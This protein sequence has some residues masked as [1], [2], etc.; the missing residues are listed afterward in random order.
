MNLFLA[1]GEQWSDTLL[2]LGVPNILFSYFYFR[3]KL[4]KDGAAGFLQ[5]KKL[6]AAKKL[7]YR[8]M[9]DSGAF[10]YQMKADQVGR[11]LP[12]PEGYHREYLDFLLDYGDIFD[13]ICELDIDGVVNDPK[14]G[15]PITVQQVDE[16]TNDL[17]EH[18]SLRKKIMPVYHE[19]RGLAWFDDW[20]ADVQSPLMGISSEFG[21]NVGS[22]QA[23]I[24][25]A[26]R[27]GKYVHGFAQTRIK[28]DLKW[29]T[30]DSV[31]STTWLRADQYGGTMIWR[32]NQLIVLDHKHKA[33]RGKYRQWFEGWGL[34][35]NKVMADDLETM[36]HATIITWREMA[37]FFS[38]KGKLPYLYEA[39]IIEGKNPTVH[40]KL[41]ELKES[42]Q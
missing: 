37:K 10:T 30:W 42:Q 18:E 19:H 20:C 24:A 22:T 4:A 27:W 8:F 36:R 39:M 6:R 16:W 33:D 32:N 34:D 15:Q 26:H 7:G 13:V 14:T 29:T 31:D 2:Q 3:Q 41:K 25:R 9:L 17:L 38:K 28:T 1:G 21:V 5:L 40:P 23:L 12:N 11:S 35:F